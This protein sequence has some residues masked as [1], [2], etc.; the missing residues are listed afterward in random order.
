MPLVGEA[1]FASP[2]WR[3]WAANDSVAEASPYS[4]TAPFSDLL[5]FCTTVN[6]K[7]PPWVLG[8]IVAG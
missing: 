4:E 8:S 2:C 3:S 5:V 7:S 1:L 6:N